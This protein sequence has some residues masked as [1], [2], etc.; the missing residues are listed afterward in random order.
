[1]FVLVTVRTDERH[2]KHLPSEVLLFIQPLPTMKAASASFL[3]LAAE[4]TAFSAPKV[5][6]NG[7]PKSMQNPVDNAGRRQILSSLVASGFS[8]MMAFSKVQSAIA[9][10]AAQD[11]LD[12][13]NF[14]R[15]GIDLGGNM[16]VSSQA[17]KSRPQTGV[18]LRD[19]SEV[20][21]DSAGNVLAEILTGSKANPYAVLVSFGSPWKLET[22]PVFDIECRDAKTGDGAFVAV[23]NNV[24]GRKLDDLPSSFFLDRLFESTG[25]FSFYGP[26]TDV[27]IRKSDTNGNYRVIEV[28]YSN[29]SQSTNAEIPRRAVLVATI[30][31]GTNNAVMLVGSS[32]ATRWRKGSEEEVRNTIASF[33]AIPAPK[34][35]LKLRSKPRGGEPID[36]T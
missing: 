4:A 28:S 24:S 5:G 7:V 30:P 12:V 32:T 19:G 14:L 6:D 26:P 27:K 3:L 2:A 36:F 13:E 33:R 23:T 8:G 10:P 17:G 21:Q 25:R 9:A 31:A 18:V 29:L 1:M 22:G 35:N 20:Q 11:S 34:S 16:G 15:T